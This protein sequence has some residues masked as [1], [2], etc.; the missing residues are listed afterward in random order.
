M[1]EHD[2]MEVQRPKTATQLKRNGSLARACDLIKKDPRAKDKSVE[3]V[4]KKDGTKD[5]F[6]EMN[7]IPIFQQ[8]SADL[9]GS[10]LSPFQDLVL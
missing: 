6:V 10:F 7:N 3:I 4:W 9:I 5:R 8:I 2:K 1:D